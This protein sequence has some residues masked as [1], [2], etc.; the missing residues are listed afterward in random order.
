M[1]KQRGTKLRPSL[2]SL[3]RRELPSALGG[4]SVAVHRASSA[5]PI[6]IPVAESGGGTVTDASGTPSATLSGELN[7]SWTTGSFVGT[8]NVTFRNASLKGAGRGTG[9]ITDSSGTLKFKTTQKLVHGDVLQGTLTV[10]GGSQDYVGSGGSFR[11]TT[12]L[13]SEQGGTFTISG[14]FDFLEGN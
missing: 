13:T 8:L 3:D 7:G 1:M 10:V 4:I 14:K 6:K 11:T 9:T 5:H 12:T 2:E